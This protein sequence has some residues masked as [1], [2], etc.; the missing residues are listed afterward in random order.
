MNQNERHIL[1]TSDNQEFEATKKLGD[2]STKISSSTS[3]N[4]SI[5]TLMEEIIPVVTHKNE[6]EFGEI[7]IITTNF[8][9]LR[10]LGFRSHEGR[11]F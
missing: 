2:V 5:E 4:F 9:M 6:F 3:S 10:L 7:S 1:E 11:M 8:Q